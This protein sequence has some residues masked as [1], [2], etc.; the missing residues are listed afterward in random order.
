MCLI[1]KSINYIRGIKI[2]I[3]DGSDGRTNERTKVFQEVLADLK[4]VEKQD[5]SRWFHKPKQPKRDAGQEREGGCG[6]RRRSL[7]CDQVRRKFTFSTMSLTCHISRQMLSGENAETFQSLH[8]GPLW[9]FAR[10]GD[11]LRPKLVSTTGCPKKCNIA[12]CS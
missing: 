2:S 6:G 10:L 5:G 7:Q 8:S 4:R 12:F 1:S 9:N 11:K 3:W